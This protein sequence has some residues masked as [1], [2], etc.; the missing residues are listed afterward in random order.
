MLKLLITP[1]AEIDLEDIYNHTFITWGLNQAEK[2]QDELFQSIENILH[3]HEFV[4]SIKDGSSVSL[5]KLTL[6]NSSN[7]LTGHVIL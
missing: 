4:F 5:R 2:Y 3:N 1:Q 6:D 7:A